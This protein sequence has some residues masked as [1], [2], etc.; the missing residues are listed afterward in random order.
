[1]G[2]I[3]TPWHI[4]ELMV[5]LVAFFKGGSI[6]ANSFS[7]KGG[8]AE[9]DVCLDPCAGTGTFLLAFM[10]KQ[11]NEYHNREEAKENLIGIEKSEY[12]YVLSLANM[13]AR[14]DGK[15][16]LQRKD[17]LEDELQFPKSP[18]I[19]LM[20]PP[21]IGKEIKFLEGLLDNLDK[22]G[23]A[24]VIVQNSTLGQTDRKRIAKKH[25]LKAVIKMPNSLFQPVAG[26][27]TSVAI[28]QVKT[29]G[30][31]KENEVYFYNLE[32]D[33]FEVENKIRDDY[34]KR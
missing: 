18:N 23:Y 25:T 20:N 30:H 14:K 28:F 8:I 29:G 22:D 16:N 27:F 21:Y 5:D 34:H 31:K 9:D 15:A 1:L 11:V 32:E 19:G 26:V 3:L 10:N 17:F 13:L 4:A 7:V 6:E 12:M 24:A 2:I 33:G